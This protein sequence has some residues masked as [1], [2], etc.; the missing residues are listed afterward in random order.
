[1]GDSV[2]CHLKSD[3][4]RLTIGELELGGLNWG[5]KIRVDCTELVRHDHRKEKFAGDQNSSSCLNAWDLW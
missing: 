2:Q 1:M 4:N 5:S 3:R